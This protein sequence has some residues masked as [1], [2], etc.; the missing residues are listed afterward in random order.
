MNLLALPLAAVRKLAARPGTPAPHPLVGRWVTR[1]EKGGR[2]LTVD[3][4]FTA[5][6]RFV[7]TVREAGLARGSVAGSY[8][9]TEETLTLT[10]PG[11]H[12]DAMPL[13][14]A[15]ADEFRN[16][17]QTWKRVGAASQ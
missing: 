15:G 4:E 14:W 5:A 13:W 10:F 6:G 12:T 3:F 9:A 16:G 1:A 2:E 8:A 11:G 7:T 17:E